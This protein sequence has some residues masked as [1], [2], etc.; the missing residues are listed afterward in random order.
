M[1]RDDSI[2]LHSR[3]GWAGYHPARAAIAE[4]LHLAHVGH[5]AREVLIV[6][7]EREDALDG[8]VD[9]DSLLDI[10][11]TSASAHTQHALEFDIGNGAHQHAQ[12]CKANAAAKCV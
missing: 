1:R 4:V 7:P 12:T 9:A 5:E 3:A 6:R 2:P 11:G 10:D 8:G